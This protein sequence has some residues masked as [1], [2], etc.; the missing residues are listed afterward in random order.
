[1]PL[2][3]LVTLTNPYSRRGTGSALSST[4]AN[5]DTDISNE[6]AFRKRMP[7]LVGIVL[8]MAMAG[9]FVLTTQEVNPP[10]EIGDSFIYRVHR[11]SLNADVIEKATG[12]YVFTFNMD[13]G[14]W[15][16]KIEKAPDGKWL[17]HLR[18]R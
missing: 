13:S 1:M 17:I 3:T 15:P 12:R 8:L 10:P 11:L 4:M 5:T 14:P 7:M 6:N 16:T 9:H 18:E 2:A